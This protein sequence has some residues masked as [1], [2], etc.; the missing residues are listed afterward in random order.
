MITITIMSTAIT[1]MTMPTPMPEKIIRKK[2]FKR[3][4]PLP[5]RHQ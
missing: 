5:C 4:D 3:Y 1:I 2:R